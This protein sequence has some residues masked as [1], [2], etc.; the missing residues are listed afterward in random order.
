MSLDEYYRRLE[1]P[2]TASATEVKRAYRRL[3]AKYHPDRNK[4]REASV[5]P[6]FKRIQE[7]FEILIGERKAP[8]STATPASSPASPPA[9]TKHREPEHP[10][11]THRS[12]PPMRGVNCMTELFV[13]LEVAIH[14]GDVEA[15]YAVKGPCC[16]CHGHAR[17]RC[18]TCFGKGVTAY[19]KCETVNV[20]P[21]AWD[22]QRVVIE[23]AGH[24]GPNGGPAGDA[25]FSVVIVCS[26]SF[27]R[28][29]LHVACDISVDFVTAMLG[30]RFEAQVL[31]RALQVKIEP[32]S[33]PGS[34]IRLR[35]QGLSDRNG[36]RGD[37]TL[38]MVLDMP[39]AA[40]HLTEDERER[41]REMFATAQRRA[42][43]FG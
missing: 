4:G 18:P 5:E 16:H 39:A 3:R 41:L 26:S 10:S 33:G 20:S 28:D 32:N 29:G 8:L 22:G 12:A 7:A 9:S 23:G 11:R 34:T 1:L 17:S 6:L 36:M 19:R 31:G 13:P 37:L 24:P 15:N 38:R 27:R 2:S 43:K 35:G 30:G 14:G 21:G 25:I 40:L 42:I